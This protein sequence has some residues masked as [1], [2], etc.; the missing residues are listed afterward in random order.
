M[1]LDGW[2]GAVALAS[3]WLCI[4]DS[5]IYPPVG[6]TAIERKMST[7]LDPR[8][9]R[10]HVLPLNLVRRS[11]RSANS[12]LI[13]QTHPVHTWKKY[14]SPVQTYYAAIQQC[15]S[16]TLTTYLSNG[17]LAHYLLLHWEMFTPIF[18]ITSCLQVK[19]SYETDRQTNIQTRSRTH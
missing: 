6:S 9:A 2:E 10:H 15:A 17:K 8:C 14:V 19:D 18:S 7:H 11:Q 3:Q 16:Q 1:K 13:F 4:T 12:S 5:V